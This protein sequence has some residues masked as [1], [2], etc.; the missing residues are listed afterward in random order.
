MAPILFG[1][2]HPIIFPKS[3]KNP[4]NQ[5]KMSSGEGVP[6]YKVIYVT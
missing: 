6:F 2:D 1:G 3:S 4:W 5:E